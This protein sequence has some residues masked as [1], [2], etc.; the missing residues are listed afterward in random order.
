MDDDIPEVCP[1]AVFAKKQ[2][3]LL[4]A[5][6]EVSK[7]LGGEKLGTI[8]NWAALSPIL[9]MYPTITSHTQKTLRRGGILAFLLFSPTSKHAKAT[10]QKVHVSLYF[11]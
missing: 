1:D 5:T 7:G 11:E 4:A 3:R 9:A 8:I 10:L 6:I 2:S